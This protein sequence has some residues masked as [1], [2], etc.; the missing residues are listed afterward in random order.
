MS[1][2]GVSSS[3]TTSMPDA[4]TLALGLL[5]GMPAEVRAALAEDPFTALESLGFELRLRAEPEITGTCSVAASLDHG[6]PPRITVVMAAS[7]GRQHFSAL[8]EFGHSRIKADTSIHDVFFDQSDLGEHLEEDVCDALAG[9]LLMPG[10]HVDAHISPDGPTAASVIDLVASTPNASREACC[11]RA[12][13]RVIGP[14]HV[15][16]IRGGTALFT[17]SHSTPY[18]VRRGTPQGAGHLAGRA[19]TAGTARGEASVT[20]AS[21]AKSDMFFVDAAYDVEEDLIVAVFMENRP[22]WERGL[23]LPN[24]DRTGDATVD[25]YC[26]HCEV[27]FVAIGAPHRACDGYFHNGDDGCGRCACVPAAQ[28]ALCQ[29]CFLRRPSSNFSENPKI[30]DIC[31]GA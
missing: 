30:C 17:A 23:A 16:V 19:A 10:S 27:D 13:E 22:P 24:R 7:Q 31:L 1:T 11:V 4:R 25:A 20:Y 28:D 26:I 8:H 9:E 3:H 18:R 14:G 29:E 6:P 15:M 21:N 5:D 12:A 2:L